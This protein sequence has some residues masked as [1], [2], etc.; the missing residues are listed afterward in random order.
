MKKWLSGVICFFSHRENFSAL[1]VCGG[2]VLV[3]VVFY[4]FFSPPAEFPSGTA[5]TI[6]EGLSVE[7][8]AQQLQEQQVVRSALWFR[9]AVLLLGG[10]R[11]IKA[12]VYQFEK[13]L[14]VYVIASR[15]ISGDQ[16]VEP[17]RITVPEGLSIQEVANLL[18]GQVDLFSQQAFVRHAEG[19]EGYLFPD[20]YFFAPDA[21]EESIVDVMEHTF[22]KRID[23]IRDEIDVFDK[24]L[25]EVV[26]MASIL[27]KEARDFEE[28]RIISGILWKR[29]ED[30]MPLQ[31]DAT[32]LYINGKGSFDLTLEDLEDDSSPYN[33]Y[34][35][36]GLPPGPIANPGLES[37]E[38]AV[39]PLET[40]YYFYLHGR[41]GE[42]R[43]AETFDGHVANKRQYLD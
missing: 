13:P 35:H 30:G 31:V 26:T 39:T 11:G 28:R 3:G 14:T 27:E 42:I 29:I 22:W 36:A 23:E 32:F 12:G 5:V 15:V 43:Y 37:L 25:H 19:K 17:H 38:A 16:N 21:D 34:T 40:R 2:A 1:I 6:E 18:D 8:V 24:T 41:D 7:E 4:F 10:E 20:T 9:S 33:T